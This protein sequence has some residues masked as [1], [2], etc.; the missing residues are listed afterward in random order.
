MN[1]PQIW[2]GFESLLPVTA[3][4]AILVFFAREAFELVKKRRAEARKLSAL[5]LVLARECELNKWVISQLRDVFQDLDL[6]SDDEPDPKD[7]LLFSIVVKEDG[8]PRARILKGTLPV[9]SLYRL[10]H[11]YMKK[12]DQFFMEVATI[13]KELFGYLEAAY[14]G[15]VNV[16]HVRDSIAKPHDGIKI[17]GEYAY[18]WGLGHYGMAELAKAEVSLTALYK[19][20]TGKSEFKARIR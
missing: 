2:S 12:M 17:L 9:E 6:N 19:N 11:A 18:F 1:F 5:K 4:V 20:C 13:D 10:P 15:M 8:E 7:A 3:V 14:D 16:Q